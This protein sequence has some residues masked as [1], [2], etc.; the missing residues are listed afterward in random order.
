MTDLKLRSLERKYK[1]DP[2]TDNWD[3]LTKERE[4]AGM[5][6][7]FAMINGFGFNVPKDARTRED[8]QPYI[9]C[10]LEPNDCIDI[11]LDGYVENLPYG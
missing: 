9:P 3:R 5:L 2:T 4:R 6:G 7:A 10:R 8:I 1:Y 11:H